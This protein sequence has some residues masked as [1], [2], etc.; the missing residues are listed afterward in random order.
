[1]I[2][3]GSGRPDRRPSPTLVFSPLAWLKLQFFLHAGNTEIGGFGVSNEEPLYIEDFVTIPQKTSCVTVEFDDAAVADYFDQQVDLG[4]V[5]SQFARIWIHTHPGSSPHPSNTDEATFARVFGR[6]DWAVMFIIARSGQMYAR[7]QFA[8]GPGATVM[9]PVIVDWPMWQVNVE[10]HAAQMEDL[11]EAWMNE[12]GENIRPIADPFDL[13]DH[14]VRIPVRPTVPADRD[15]IPDW[16]EWELD[17]DGGALIRVED[18][19]DR[20]RR[21][22]A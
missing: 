13:L 12:Y 5:P 19:Y 20:E 2:W 11:L 1:M 21:V 18:D 16:E 14:A 7:M 8:A 9:L 15:T 22:R 3:P 17:L 4:K 6:C 10:N